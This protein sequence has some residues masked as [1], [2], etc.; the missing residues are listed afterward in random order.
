MTGR[1]RLAV[2]AAAVAVVVGLTPLALRQMRFF[3]VRQVEVVGA[4]YLVPADI[5]AAL[6]LEPGQNLFDPL[7]E[8][9]G[10]VAALPGVVH[11]E[12]TRRVPGTLRVTLVE[13]EPV[14]LASGR[15]GMLPL[16]CDGTALPYDPSHAGLTLPILERA[17]SVLAGALCV[18]RASDSALYAAVHTV[19]AGGDGSVLL[20]LG[21]QRVRLGAT[22]SSRDVEAV[23]LVRRH[24]AE[25]GRPFRELD[26]RYAGL[27]YAREQQS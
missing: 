11:V 17:D 20:D 14:G 12:V 6:D 22:P 23:V 21:E 16:D 4:R 10:R 27:V 9:E 1:A 15:E 5:V 7:G 13:R 24:L 2:I 8:A 19:R 18:V 25:T 3:D 26:A